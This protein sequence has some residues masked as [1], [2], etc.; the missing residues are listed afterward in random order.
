MPFD[1]FLA[2]SSQFSVVTPVQE[3]QRSQP[4]VQYSAV[5]GTETRLPEGIGPALPLG[6][7]TGSLLVGDLISGHRSE[8]VR[9]VEGSL[10]YIQHVAA[11]L[12]ID[13]NDER[14]VDA[15]VAKRTASLAAR[16]LRRRD[17]D[18]R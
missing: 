9:T 14:I 11:S 1:H 16:P 7:R 17:N 4:R 5:V 6:N 12:P 15:L 3:G 10:Q 8:V 13:R 2:L 18:S